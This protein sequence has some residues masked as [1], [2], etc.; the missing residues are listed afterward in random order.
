M[1]R[2][3]AIPALAAKLAAKLK[4]SARLAKNTSG[5]DAHSRTIGNRGA[6]AA[7]PHNPIFLLDRKENELFKRIAVFMFGAVSYLVF[8]GSFIYAC[9]FIGNF[10]HLKSLDSPGEG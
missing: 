3:E 1:I 5:A 7:L 4:S 8:F 10:A 6:A 2:I 9:M